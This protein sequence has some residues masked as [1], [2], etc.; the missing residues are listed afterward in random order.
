MFDKHEGEVMLG[1]GLVHLMDDILCSMDASGNIYTWSA[2]WGYV[3]HSIKLQT[4]FNFSYNGVLLKLS[5]TKLAVE[6]GTNTII[7]LGHDQGRNICVLDHLKVLDSDT[8]SIVDVASHNEHLVVLDKQGNVAVWNYYTKMLIHKS[9]GSADAGKVAINDW[10]IAVIYNRL[11]V[12]YMNGG[13]YA[14]VMRLDLKSC[15]KVNEITFPSPNYLMASTSKAAIFVSLISGK[16]TDQVELKSRGNK[17]LQTCSSSVM[18]DGRICIGSNDGYIAFY[19]PPESLRAEIKGSSEQI[20][21]KSNNIKGFDPPSKKKGLKDPTEEE[22]EEIY[23]LK[24][25][26]RFILEGNNED[27]KLQNLE[28]QNLKEEQLTQK[29]KI[30]EDSERI[31]EQELFQNTIKEQNQSLRK[32]ME[33]MKESRK[34]SDEKMKELSA[35]I[36][37]LKDVI[38]GLLRK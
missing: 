2:A 9:K 21:N 24:E 22:N 5:E 19:E 25:E 18:L 34:I 32:E 23:L 11:G 10:F 29:I 38:S 1:Q 13:E 27:K 4:F 20:H 36:G 30:K 37:F 6:N 28:M 26:L 15:K 12:F 35:E 31:M 8:P 16:V 14:E 17:T 33:E 7:I 3:I